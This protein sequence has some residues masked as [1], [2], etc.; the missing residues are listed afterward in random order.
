VKHDKQ[1]QII[2]PFQPGN[3]ANPEG[4]PKGSRNRRTQEILD[5]LKSR[6]DKDPLDF[7]SE[8]ISGN[9]EYPAELKVTASNI[10]APYVHS[11]RGA[12]VAPRF[13]GEPVQVPD[14]QSTDDAEKFLADLP[15]RVGLGELDFQSGLDLSTMTKNWISAKYEREELQLKITAQGGPTNQVIEIRGGLPVMPGHEGLI[16][17]NINGAHGQESELNGKILDLEKNA[18]PELPAPEPTFQDPQ[19]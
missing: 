11:K 10:L 2:M 9:G 12:L 6:G 5:L 3:I 7:L 16:M 1:S 14:F 13:I 4:R 15:R 19:P 17:P 8:V 18:G